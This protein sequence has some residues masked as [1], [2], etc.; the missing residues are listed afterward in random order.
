VN[1]GQ[2]T[3]S[4]YFAKRDRRDLDISHVRVPAKIIILKNDEDTK[5]DRLIA[6]ISKFANS[7]NAVKMSDLSANRPFHIQLEKLSQENWRPDGVGRW[8]YERAAGS[9]N[10]LLMRDGT[11]PAKRRQLLD[12]IPRKRVISKNDAAR[13]HEAWRQL[14][15]QVSLGGEKNLA[16][17]MTA[18]D[19]NPSLVP[20]PL[21]A[22][23]FKALV[24][25]AIIF[26][27]VQD[28]I[29]TKASKAVFRQG[30]INISVYVLALAANRL[31]DLV[32]FDEIW[33]QQTLS[34]DFLTLLYSWAG[35][36]NGVFHNFAPGRQY[37]EVAKRH[38]LWE[39]VMAVR[40]PEAPATAPELRAR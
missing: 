2:T 36:V 20:D 25:K 24:G 31:G 30:Y 17:F 3:S 11:T 27:S 4:L 19:E 8:F 22:P 26:Q 21:D 13:Y 15:A 18:L 14:P 34:P 6:D 37:S 40:Y 23:W 7:Q 10:V 35:V 38:E 1:G 5:R 16:A 32:D 28:M 33:R 12:Q 29:K 39:Q 9:Y